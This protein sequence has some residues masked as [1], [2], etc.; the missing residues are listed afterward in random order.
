MG[1]IPSGNDMSDKLT[2]DELMQM[3]IEITDEVARLVEQFR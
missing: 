3:M 2:N 1:E